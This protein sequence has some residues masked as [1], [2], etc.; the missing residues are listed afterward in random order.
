MPM[1]M[2]ML[3]CFAGSASHEF[4]TLA[5]MVVGTW[6][7]TLALGVVNFALV[8]ANGDARFKKVH[9]SWFAGYALAVAGLFVGWL[10]AGVVFALVLGIGIPIAVGVHFVALLM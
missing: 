6:I 7:G 1:I 4:A 3:A 9:F 2:P 8:C 10:D 5:Y